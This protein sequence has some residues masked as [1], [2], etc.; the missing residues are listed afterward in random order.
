[1]ILS[2]GWLCIARRDLCPKSD[3]HPE[4]RVRFRSEGLP[5]LLVRGELE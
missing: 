1:M 5:A 3:A 4:G 2:S